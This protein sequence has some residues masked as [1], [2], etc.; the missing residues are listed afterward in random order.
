MDVSRHSK[1]GEVSPVQQVLKL[2][3]S[4]DR[5]SGREGSEGSSSG[6]APTYRLTGEKGSYRFMAPEVFRHEQYN[7]KVD[8]YGFAMIAY[9]LFEGVPPFY[10]LDPIDAGERID[11]PLQVNLFVSL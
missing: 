1:A 3:N 10:M 8:I 9:Q 11:P 5:N 6:V 2:G 7:N 4:M